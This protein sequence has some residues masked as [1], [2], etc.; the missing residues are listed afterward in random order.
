MVAAGGREYEL[1]GDDTGCSGPITFSWRCR[2][3]RRSRGCARRSSDGRRMTATDDDLRLGFQVSGERMRE[4]AQER[5]KVRQGRV[6]RLGGTRRRLQ[7]IS[8]ARRRAGGGARRRRHAGACLPACE[9]EE[10]DNATFVNNPL[11]KG[12]LRIF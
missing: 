1:D 9:R 4:R 8:R 12:K 10:E 7:D 11:E 2:A 3:T 6:R 5:G